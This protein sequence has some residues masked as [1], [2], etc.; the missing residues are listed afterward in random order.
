MKKTEK[1]LYAL[2]YFQVGGQQ[3]DI[4]DEQ[5]VVPIHGP[6][7]DKTG[8]EHVFDVPDANLSVGAFLVHPIYISGICHSYSGATI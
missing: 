2:T 3:P 5:N 1:K 8:F 7:A 4:T 6:T